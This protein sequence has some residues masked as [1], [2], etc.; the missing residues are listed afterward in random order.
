VSFAGFAHGV[1][2]DAAA[3]RRSCPT[4]ETA[5]F[6]NPRPTARVI[7][8]SE[9]RGTNTSGAHAVRAEARSVQGRP[10]VAM[11]KRAPDTTDRQGGR[12]RIATEVRVPFADRHAAGE[13][14]AARLDDARGFDLVLGIARGGLPVAEAMA[15]RLGADLDAALSHKIRMPGSAQTV[16]GAVAEGGAVSWNENVVAHGALDGR[17]WAGE[18]ERATRE[19]EARERVY[20]AVLPRA[21]VRGKRVILTDDGVA[22]GATLRAAIQALVARAPASLTIALPGGRRSALEDLAT[23]DGVDSVLALASPPD[24]YAVGQLYETFT[25]VSDADA[26]RI[27]REAHHRRQRSKRSRVHAR[28]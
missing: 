23:L 24:F 25:H 16:A 26:V 27:L 18:R 10:R 9:R 8:E 4:P 2:L 3:T 28:R 21:E 22:T 1:V 7:L 5:V 17:D 19:L 14:L 15:V 11:T 12:L 13:A 20:R 6:P